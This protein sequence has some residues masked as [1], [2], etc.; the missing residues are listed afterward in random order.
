MLRDKS[1]GK[2]SRFSLVLTADKDFSGFRH[3]VKAYDRHRGRRSGRFDRTPERIFHGTYT[4]VGRSGCDHITCVQG[5]L[6][7]KHV[8]HSAFTLIQTRFQNQT[9]GTAIRI[10]LQLQHLGLQK[11][12]VHQIGDPLACLG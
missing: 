9:A 11:N 3:I 8:R 5:A 6:L 1:L 7:D 10:C 12:H 2:A 4:S